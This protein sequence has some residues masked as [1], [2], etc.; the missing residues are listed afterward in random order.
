MHQFETFCITK[1]FNTLSELKELSDGWNNGKM[2][3]WLA[4]EQYFSFLK[5]QQK[6]GSRLESSAMKWDK[7]N[8]CC[9][10]SR[11]TLVKHS[12]TLIVHVFK[13]TCRWTY[14]SMNISGYWNIIGKWRMSQIDAYILWNVI[15]QHRNETQIQFVLRMIQ[16]VLEK[17]SNTFIV[18]R[19]TKQSGPG[20]SSGKAL[21]YGLDG[22]GSIPGV[23]GVEIFL[24]S[25]V[26]RLAL[27][28]TQPP[29]KWLPGNFPG[30]KGGRA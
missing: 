2:D 1:A 23:G 24:N 17:Q 25:F 30:G 18:L 4:R 5:T 9:V 12:N 27:G 14:H 21:G 22:P 6:L 20:G 7:Y 26:S 11:K 10:W 29:I 16:K 28:S 13:Q 19:V 3:W 15:S 8:F